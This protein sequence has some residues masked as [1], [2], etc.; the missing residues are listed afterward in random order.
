VFRAI[1]NYNRYLKKIQTTIG[2]VHDKVQGLVPAM[3]KIFT[4]DGDVMK[5]FRL[6]SYITDNTSGPT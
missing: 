1:E 4:N 2:S 5:P 3:P 6:L